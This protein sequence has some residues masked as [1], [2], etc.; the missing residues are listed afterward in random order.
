MGLSM[1]YTQETLLTLKSVQFTGDDALK[2][3]YAVCYD[4]D[5]ILNYRGNVA[6]VATVFGTGRYMRVEKPTALNLQDFAGLVTRSYAAKTGGQRIEIAVPRE[7]AVVNAYVYASC[8]VNAT[9]L[10]PVPGQ[11]YLSGTGTLFPWAVKALQTVDRSSTAGLCEVA[12]A[13]WGTFEINPHQA[14]AAQMYRLGQFYD[15]PIDGRRWR[16]GYVGTGGVQSEF[17][18]CFPYKAVVNAIAPAQ[19]TGAGVADSYTV[20]ATIGASEEPAS[21]AFTVNDP[22]LVGG[23]VVIGNGTSQ[24][25]ET[26]RITGNTVLTNAGGIITLT[27]DRPLTAAVVVG[28]TNIE[29][30]FNKWAYVTS[31]NVTQSGYV[32]F[33][34]IPAVTAAAGKYVWFQTLGL[35]WVTSNSATCNSAGDRNIYLVSNGSAVS[36]DDEDTTD[37][38]RQF[39]GVA[40]DASSSGSSNAPFVNL[41]ME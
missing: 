34:G 36:G 28:T 39:I 23:Y 19:A 1:G 11:Y 15:D 9:V 41:Q 33:V 8:T 24:H 21:G 26:R 32:T 14:D 35:D 30:M 22:F 17:G 6:E 3:G 12:W 2:E 27:L 10:G 40:A 25:P 4:R 18:G 31:G 7:G 16:Y 13:K 20:S 5:A 29:I 38:T 37:N